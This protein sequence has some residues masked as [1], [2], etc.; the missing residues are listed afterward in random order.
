MGHTSEFRR[1]SH[2]LSSNTVGSSAAVLNLSHSWGKSLQDGQA[3]PVQQPHH[4]TGLQSAS[5]FP[6]QHKS[7]TVLQS[8]RHQSELQ[9]HGRHCTSSD[10]H[11]FCWGAQA[12]R[13]GQTL[14]LVKWLLP[15]EECFF[16]EKNPFLVLLAFQN[17]TNQ[18]IKSTPVVVVLV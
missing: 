3:A 8:R 2:S 13:T 9:Q 6:L 15:W 18:Q 5:S 14:G 11:A 7:S 12:V 4:F 1:T 16:K 17:Q 10:S